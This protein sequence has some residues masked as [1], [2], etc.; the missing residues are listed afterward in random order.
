VEIAGWLSLFEIVAGPTN[1]LK[2]AG[3]DEVIEVQA[4]I[5]QQSCVAFHA[6][7]WVS[8]YAFARMTTYGPSYRFFLVPC[9]ARAD[10]LLSTPAIVIAHMTQ[11]L[12]NLALSSENIYLLPDL[13]RGDPSGDEATLLQIT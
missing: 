9:D 2:L 5:P 13:R 4:I 8:Y 11:T 7:A 12:R 3:N 1:H 10:C 6:N